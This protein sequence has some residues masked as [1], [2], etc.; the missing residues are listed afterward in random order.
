MSKLPDDVHP[1]YLPDQ[2]RRVMPDL[3]P[4]FYIDNWPFGPQMLVVASPDAA[5]QITQEHSLPKYP[6]MRTFLR[7]LTGEYDLVTMEGQLWKTWRTIYNPGFSAGHLMTLVPDIVKETTIFC[8]I[9][10]EHAR[11]QDIFPLK[12]ATDNLTM[13]VISR[14]VMDT[15]INSQRS[16]NEMVSALRRQIPW[17]TF[18]TEINPIQRYHPL[19]PLV[20]WYNARQMNKY[21]SRVLEDRFAGYTNGETMPAG[22][23][24]HSKSVIDLA[25]N[26][27]LADAAANQT[28]KSSMTA[29][30]M[31]ATF[32]A[33][34]ISQI[35]L[36]I[37]S[38]H[39]T[40]SS[41]ICFVFYLLSKHPSALECLRAEY[42]EV[43]GPDLTQTASII[44]KDPHL[45]NRLPYTVA[46]LKESLRL[47]PVVSSTR[48]GEPDF[49]VVDSHG[50]QYPTEGCL[51]WSIHHAIQRDPA[52]WPQPDSFLPERWLVPQ[53]DPLHPIKG[54]WRAFEFGPRTC[55]G[56][57]LAMLEMK[58]AM[59]MTLREFD[60]KA[61]YEEWDMLKSKGGRKTVEG[62][63]A[64]Q[65][66]LAQPS[67]GLPC[68][69]K[70]AAE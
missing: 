2:L 8:D 69:V 26:T 35:K 23:A 53:G 49:S 50:R 3:G 57:E 16:H 21:I 38:G 61:A 55:I 30:G 9:L 43:F 44:A 33:F 27:Y 17:L 19:R 4:V 11:N 22:T 62:E 20:H 12:E 48:V 65:I 7:P 34:A 67:D 58:I 28:A 32:K 70:M 37:F 41:S 46:V 54:A 18:G 51:V 40:T 14:V 13:D 31:D 68:R 15:H 1:H 39:D 24:R 42:Q 52:Y 10:R 64:Y 6:A 59:V 63:R 5:Y 56:Q 66:I 36:F 25:L 45:L 29:K 60:V 47:F